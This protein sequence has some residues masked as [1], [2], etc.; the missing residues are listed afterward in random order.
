MFAPIA[1]RFEGYSIPLSGVEHAYVQSVLH[2]PCILE[3]IEAGKA[4]KEVIE[5]DEIET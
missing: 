3:W 1:L 5:E 2:Q 4:E